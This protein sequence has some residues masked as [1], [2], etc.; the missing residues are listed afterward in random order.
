VL[1]FQTHLSVTAYVHFLSGFSSLL[2]GPKFLNLA[3]DRKR[4]F[5]LCELQSFFIHPL[6]KE[7]KERCRHEHNKSAHEKKDET[8]AMVIPL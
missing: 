4:V 7:L 1:V 6:F 2:T 8:N 3:A 5:I